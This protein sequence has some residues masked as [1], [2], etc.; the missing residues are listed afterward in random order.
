MEALDGQRFPYE[1]EVIG[2]SE[3]SGQR[4]GTPF[5]GSSALVGRID[6]QLLEAKDIS[7]ISLREAIAHYGLA[8]AD[9]P[10]AVVTARHFCVSR[11]SH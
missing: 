1:I 9:L 6:E 7:D 5:L 10:D 2:F 8:A 4:F 11:I 3:E